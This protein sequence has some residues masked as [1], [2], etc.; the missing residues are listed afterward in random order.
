[1][2]LLHGK[3]LALSRMFFL[4]QSSNSIVRIYPFYQTLNQ[5][6]K[7]VSCAYDD[8]IML[9]LLIGPKGRLSLFVCLFFLNKF[10][11]GLLACWNVVKEF[12]LHC[13]S[14]NVPQ[15]SSE[16]GKPHLGREHI[17]ATNLCLSII[18]V[19]DFFFKQSIKLTA[20]IST[21]LNATSIHQYSLLCV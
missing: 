20:N 9:G 8:Y 1:M 12:R 7:T 5:S 15:N 3:L 4:M 14:Y 18:G 13:I 19:S 2:R 16:L 6:I 11:I 17:T 10:K 21:L